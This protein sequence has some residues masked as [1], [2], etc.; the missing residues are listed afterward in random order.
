MTEGLNSPPVM[1]STCCRV[2]RRCWRTRRKRRPTSLP[3]VGSPSSSGAALISA[4][5]FGSLTAVAAGP[6]GQG[7]RQQD[8]VG[9]ERHVDGVATGEGQRGR[10]GGGS[11]IDSGAGSGDDEAEHLRRV[12]GVDDRD[13]DVAVVSGDLAVAIGIGHGG[14]VRAG[15]GGPGAAAILVLAIAVA[16]VAVA[17]VAVAVVAVAVV[18]VAVVALVLVLVL[19]LGLAVV[20]LVL[21]LA[22]GLTV[23]A[24]VGGR[25]DRG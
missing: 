7:A 23:V 24:V 2:R 4:L 9:D 25:L 6:D 18:A 12:A 16:V 15:L 8:Q 10:L 19:A 14:A 13:V 20:A 21:V 17:V 11:R 1:A 5:D 22:L 3:Y